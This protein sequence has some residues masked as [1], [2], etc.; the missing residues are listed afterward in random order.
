MG[1]GGGLRQALSRVWRQEDGLAGAWSAAG[2]RS[3]RRWRGAE[4]GPRESLANSGAHCVRTPEK[5]LLLH[6]HGGHWGLRQM[7]A[8]LL[9]VANYTTFSYRDLADLGHIELQ[10][11]SDVS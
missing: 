10:E 1:R 4:A 11:K 8:N 5:G 7:T 6:R 9:M 2:T 3:F